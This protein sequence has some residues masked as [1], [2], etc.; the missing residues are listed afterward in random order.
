MKC[1]LCG[2]ENNHKREGK[3]RDDESINILECDECSLVFLDKQKCR[4]PILCHL[5]SS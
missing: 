3:V 4:S 5:H 2:S 1:Y